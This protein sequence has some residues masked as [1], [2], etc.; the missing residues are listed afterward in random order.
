MLLLANSRK[1]SKISRKPLN[2]HPT[3]RHIIKI[4]VRPTK[5]SVTLIAP[6]AT[7]I[8]P[9]KLIS[10]S[11]K[12][13]VGRANVYL[14]KEQLKLAYENGREAVRLNPKSALA[15]NNF[16]WIKYRRGMF[17]EAIEDFTRAIT[18]DSQLTIAY[19]NRGIVKTEL[20]QFEGAIRDFN[21]ALKLRPQV[22]HRSL[23][24]RQRMDWKKRL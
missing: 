6:L 4:V 9:L 21:M 19:S 18:Y 2:F 1:L 7:S 23:Q 5:T 17:D 3:I 11:P 15:L 13:I 10:D 12:L 24:S 22:I 8:V 20:N 14:A 16:G